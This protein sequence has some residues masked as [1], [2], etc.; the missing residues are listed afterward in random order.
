MNIVVDLILG[1]QLLETQE[2]VILGNNTASH[3]CIKFAHKI[4]TN[5]RKEMV[6]YWGMLRMVKYITITRI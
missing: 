3:L 4:R 5:C 1:F 2:P 6:G